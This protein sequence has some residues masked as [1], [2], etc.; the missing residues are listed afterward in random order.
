MPMPSWHCQ[1]SPGIENIT[2]NK[3][4]YNRNISCVHTMFISNEKK[5]L[6]SIIDCTGFSSSL[7]MTFAID[8]I[9]AYDFI[10]MKEKQQNWSLF[11]NNEETSRFYFHL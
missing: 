1:Q 3:I 8:I 9:Y 6:N 4:I 5:Q 11:R 7:Y 2:R 10:N